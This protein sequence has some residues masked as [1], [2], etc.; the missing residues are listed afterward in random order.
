MASLLP[1]HPYN[2]GFAFGSQ[3]NVRGSCLLS[4][5]SWYFDFT[6]YRVQKNRVMSFQVR[7]RFGLPLYGQAVSLVL[8]L[9]FL[10]KYFRMIFLK[11][12]YLSF[13]VLVWGFVQMTSCHYWKWKLFPHPFFTLIRHTLFKSK[14]A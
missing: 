9:Q 13:S 7:S 14:A 8:T 6:L 11:K 1:A 4:Q 3:V 12:C 2:E 5:D 10:V